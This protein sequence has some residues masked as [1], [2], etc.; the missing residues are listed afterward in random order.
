M[1][2]IYYKTS[3]AQTVEAWN[4]YQ[5]ESDK[6]IAAYMAFAKDWGGKAWFRSGLHGTRFAGLTFDPVKRDPLWTKPDRHD[7]VQRP[8][9]SLQGAT[10]EQ[11]AALAGLKAKWGSGYPKVETD[12]APVL[13]AMGTSHGNL[14]FSGAFSVFVRGVEMYCATGAKLAPH[15]KEILAS[16]FEAAKKVVDERKAA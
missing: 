11:K 13:A 4:L 15:F 14:I 9:A 5:A 2:T 12:F 3:D 6:A 1:T 8:R 10:P 7:R 16:E